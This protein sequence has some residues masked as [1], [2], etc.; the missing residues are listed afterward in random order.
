MEMHKMLHVNKY[1]FMISAMSTGEFCDRKCDIVA[2]EAGFGA[3]MASP[4][5][6]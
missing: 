1:L 6:Y 4:R 3:I 5:I 2:R